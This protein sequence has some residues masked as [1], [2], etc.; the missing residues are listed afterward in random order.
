MQP[1]RAIGW[2]LVPALEWTSTG[3]HWW[4]RDYSVAVRANRMGFRDR[5]RELAKP[6]GAERVALLGDSFVQAIQVPLEKTAGALLERRLRPGH[7]VLNFGISN[8]GVGQ[9]LLTWEAYAAGFQPDLVVA[10]VGGFHMRRSVAPFQGSLLDEKRPRLWVRPTFRLEGGRLL[11]EPARDYDK[12]VQAQREVVQRHY[13]G[14]RARR[15]PRG[16]FLGPIAQRLSS[17]APAPAAEPYP[18]MPEDTV[19]VNLAVLAEL[20]R[21]VGAQG[22]RLA[23]ADLLRYFEPADAPVSARLQR[24]CAERG[25][26]Y[27]PVSDRLIAANREGVPTRWAHDGHFNEAGNRVFA[28]AIQEWMSAHR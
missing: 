5:E 12:F 8:F 9:Y 21:S 2:K 10:F 6:A 17:L 4:A 15:R 11:R 28:E 24:L 14:G 22:G 25:L 19:A 20:G 1:D 27:I 13:G 3:N 16:L 26:G 23:I 7:E 18:G